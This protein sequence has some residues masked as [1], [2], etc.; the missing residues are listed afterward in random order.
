MTNIVRKQKL[1][2]TKQFKDEPAFSE[3]LS[4]NLEYI[5]F[6]Q[7]DDLMLIE[8]EHRVGDF[9]ADIVL[10]HGN[11]ILVVENQWGKSDHDHLGKL[12]TYGAGKGA[13]VLVWICEKLRDEHRCVIDSLQAENRRI[14]ACEVSAISLGE[15]NMAIDIDVICKPNDWALRERPK[16]VIC[17]PQTLLVSDEMEQDGF[18]LDKGFHQNCRR[19]C[20]TTYLQSITNAASTRIEV[21][22]E[23]SS[24][25]QEEDLAHREALRLVLQKYGTQEDLEYSERDMKNYIFRLDPKVAPITTEEHA[26]WAIL[27]LRN[28]MDALTDAGLITSKAAN[29]NIEYLGLK[30]GDLLTFIRDSSITATVKDSTKIEFRGEITSLSGAAKALIGREAAGPN[31]WLHD[32]RRLSDIRLDREANGT[33]GPQE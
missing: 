32:G 3:W 2:I 22:I 1:D 16:A 33:Y 29:I 18:R 14:F 15:N 31:W 25:S 12:L 6:T 7:M 28:L 19:I 5:D 24:R 11:G 26:N 20:L 17:T 9:R 4:K 21:I 13:N 10:S 23:P 27:H 8:T 30:D